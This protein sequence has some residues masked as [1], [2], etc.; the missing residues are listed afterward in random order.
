MIG[1]GAAGQPT[2][3]VDITE[4]PPGGGGRSQQL[5]AT[6]RVKPLPL[7]SKRESQ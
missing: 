1:L 7:A 5:V 6:L 3:T 4:P 2:K